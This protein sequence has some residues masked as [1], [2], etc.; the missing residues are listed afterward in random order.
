MSEH[1]NK[2]SPAELE[3][4][5]LLAEE[6]SEV[7]HMCMKIMRHGYENYHPRYPTR[8]NRLLLALELGEMLG[9]FEAM[10]RAGDFRAEEL[11]E[12]GLACHDKMRVAAPY[13]HHQ[14][15]HNE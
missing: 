8:N 12:L 11:G 2:L 4:L 9:V 1:F 5:A 10:K 6:A 13:L 14:G 15:A 7:V 3:R